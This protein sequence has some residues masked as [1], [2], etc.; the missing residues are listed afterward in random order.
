MRC[1]TLIILLA[2]SLVFSAC[3]KKED[4]SVSNT[5]DVICRFTDDGGRNVVI[6]RKAATIVSLAPSISEMVD[7]LGY[8]GM[9]R[10]VTEWCDTPGAQG[11]ERLGSMTTPDVERIITIHP[12]LVIGT[13]MTPRHIYDTLEAA[14]ITCVMFKH[15]GLT[16]VMAD[17]RQLAD[18][19]G[20]HEAGARVV[21]GMEK[22]KSAI[23]A[24]VP[25]TGK[26]KVALMYDLDSMGSAGKGSWVDDMLASVGLDN[27]A[28]R[29]RSAWPRLSREAL[30][31][32]QPRFVIIPDRLDPAESPALRAR[33]EK[34]RTDPVWSGVDAIREGRV[35]IVPANY[36]NIPG[37][38]SL[39]AMQVLFD[40]VYAPDG[41][42]R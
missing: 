1:L 37:P 31:T 6:K 10:G 18:V 33:V 24:S 39:N 11:A 41:T 13:E 14:G 16:D 8:A 27:I 23:L 2:F 9:L 29:A 26:V 34:L 30:L 4:A 25:K 40:A 17:M 22:R 32:E 20:E 15:G 28:N 42:T 35:I 3:G 38:R 36:L 7:V 21:D 12:D 19:L 5:P